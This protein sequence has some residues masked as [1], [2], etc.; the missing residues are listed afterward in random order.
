M[1]RRTAT[2][3]RRF[4]WLLAAAIVAAIVVAVLA[5]R[6]GTEVTATRAVTGPL[7]LRIAASGLVEAESADLSF[8]AAGHISAI[9]AEEGQQVS[10]S[11]AL[12]WLEPI[13]AA[14]TAMD[15]GD[16]I[17]AP[18]AGVVVEIYLRVGATVTP[19]QPVLR[20]VR[21]AGRWVTAFID[22]E[23]AAGVRPGQK[24]RC[25]AGG[26]LSRPWDLVVRSVGREAVPRRDL[27]GSSRQV[28]VRCDPVAPAFP[29]APGTEVDVDGEVSLAHE[30][31][32]IPA[33]AVVREGPHDWVW[34]VDGSHARRREVRLG[35]NNFD[36]VQVLSGLQAGQ[37]VVTHGKTGLRD[38]QMVRVS[39]ER[40]PTESSAGER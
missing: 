4:R 30:A 38:G 9:D 26:Y 27:L 32:L 1:L 3:I 39:W 25:R 35:P 37:A 15:I 24:L 10:R 34:L 18:D 33:A 19:G 23:D 8:A 11:Q 14:P 36:L 29:I 21:A 17:R 40:P 7:L 20:V 6:H 5:G 13:G 22:S 12:A 28:R 16:V 31:L 2:Y